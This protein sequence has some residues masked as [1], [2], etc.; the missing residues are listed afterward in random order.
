MIYVVSTIMFS[1]RLLDLI[2]D[3]P[4][5]NESLIFTMILD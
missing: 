4:V 3:S 1:V 2:N 5:I